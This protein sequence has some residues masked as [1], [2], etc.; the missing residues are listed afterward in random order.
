VLLVSRPSGTADLGAG[1]G[2]G[3]ERRRVAAQLRHPRLARVVRS[4][5]DAEGACVV[6]EIG[7]ARPLSDGRCRLPRGDAL[8]RELMR[9]LEAIAYL[10]GQGISHGAVMRESVFSDGR[11]LLLTGHALGDDGAGSQAD[12]LRGWA[13]LSLELLR[14]S[15]GGETAEVVQEAASQ[16]VTALASGRSLDA[17]RVVRA[18]NGALSDSE[19][20]TAPD[21]EEDADEIDRSPLMKALTAVG[22]ATGSIV[23]GL[24]TTLLTLAVIGVAVAAGVLWFLDQLPGEL[25]VPNV[26]GMERDEAR[27]RLE[28]EGLAVGRVRSVY[29]EEVESGHVAETVPPPGMTVREGREVTLVVSMGAARVRVPRVVGLR[30]DEAQRVLEKQGLELVDGGKTRSNMPEGEIVRQDPPSGRMI[31]QGQRIVVYTSGGP[32]F[33]MIEMPGDDEEDEAQRIVFRRVEIIVPRGDALQR[34]EVREGYGDNLEKTYDRLHRPGDR[35]K[36]DTYGR[37]GKQIKV[38]IEG[39]QVF[40]TQF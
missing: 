22:Q 29:R 26:V 20:P 8:A 28:R 6:E 2:E 14:A 17:A 18:I 34:V 32:R 38:T 5:H 24:F 11:E 9:V 30:L 40:T 1:E 23:M 7:D 27:V 37:P 10:H 19:E 35:I 31:A 21:A 16:V 13:E 25:P 12:D 3:G 33:A 36:L 4:D 15:P 39:E